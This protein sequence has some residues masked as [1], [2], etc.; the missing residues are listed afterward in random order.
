MRKFL[1]ATVLTLAVA[2]T[3]LAAAPAAQAGTGPAAF[4][5][6]LKVDSPDLYGGLGGFAGCVST[7]AAVGADALDEGAFPSIAAA[8]ANCKMLEKTAFVADGGSAYP[9]TF[10]GDVFS[11]VGVVT[12]LLI[13]DGVPPEVAAQLAPMIVANYLANRDAF[14]ANNRAGCVQV[15]RRLHS[16][17]LF[18]LIFPAG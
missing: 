11:N 5:R 12:G 2:S 14:T 1:T 15:L 17:E 8:I 13:E 4:C 6:Q 18:G 3:G 7:I 10:Y 16:G 9:Y